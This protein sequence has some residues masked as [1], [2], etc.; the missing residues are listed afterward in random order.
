MNKNKIFI[1][2]ILGIVALALT[3]VIACSP[4]TDG[5]TTTAGSSGTNL[6]LLDV[7]GAGAQRSDPKVGD[8]ADY[9]YGHGPQGDVIRIY[10]YVLM[11]RGNSTPSD[12]YPIVDTGQTTYYTTNIAMMAAP[13]TGTTFDGQ[14][15]AHSGLQPSYTDNGD[16]TVSDNIT[17]LMWTKSC[18]W[19]GDGAI[20]VDDKMTFYNATNYA[21]S[22][23]NG[24]YTD[25][26]TPSIKELYSLMNFNGVD[27]SGY[28]GTSTNGLT[29]FIDNAYF[30]F[31]YGDQAAGERIIDSQMAST[32]IYTSTTF[33][34]NITMFGVN[35]A[36]GRIK[37]YPIEHDKTFYVY[38]VR[39]DT[40][41]GVNQFVNNGDGTIS[42]NATGL[43]WT[44]ADG[45]EGLDWIEALEYV[46]T[47]NS[48]SYLGHNDWRLPNIKELQSIL[49][50]TRS[51]DATDSPAI[52]SL[53]TLT[54][55]EVE[56]GSSNYAFYWSGTTHKYY[57]GGSTEP[58]QDGG[59]AAYMAFGE[60]LGWM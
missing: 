36:D 35:F 6:S 51:P 34:N 18:D 39:G 54:E 22:V 56:D 42:D 27:P 21:S 1:S 30:D 13:P 10:N 26:R 15:A 50:Y 46:R 12:T 47:K 37:G 14:D 44:Q 2:T 58:A 16:E 24:G 41:Y 60:A 8:P 5:T 28:A 40:D 3:A 20:D 33:E 38:Y 31:G 4:E 43:M 25:W 53:F 52:N 9:P 45:G 48:E 19:N 23:T 7:H 57:Y 59:N 49:D 17:G 29:P 32:A 11:V 55:I